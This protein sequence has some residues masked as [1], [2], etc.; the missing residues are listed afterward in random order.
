MNKVNYLVQLKILF[1]LQA[2]KEY[3]FLNIKNVE[4]LQSV[5]MINIL[6]VSI[7]TANNFCLRHLS[8]FL[9]SLNTLLMN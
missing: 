1:D 9:Q 4:T 5:T 8:L 6:I 7:T 3:F 2:I